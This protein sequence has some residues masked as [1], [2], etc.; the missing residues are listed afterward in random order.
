M[1]I[2]HV[3]RG[4]DHVNNTPRQINILRALGA[5]VPTYA[6]VSMILGDDG[7]K[8]SKR[9]GAVERHGVQKRTATCRRRSSI[10][11][12][13]WAGR[14]ATTRSSRAS[15]WSNG[16]TWTTSPVS[17]PVQHGKTQL[18]ERA[19]HQ[20]GRWRARLTALVQKRLDA[21]AVKVAHS[22]R[23]KRS[24][25]STKERVGNLN[26]ARRRGRRMFYID[27]HPKAEILAQ[28]LTDEA[29]PAL[30]DF[31]EA[32]KTVAWDAPAIGALIKETVGK[33]GRRCQARHAAARAAHRA[34]ADPSVDAVVALFPRET[35]YWHDTRADAK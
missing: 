1:G 34:G 4:D 6:H 18:A 8:L 15:S 35:R 22:R 13:G 14:T 23:W 3:I 7:Q 10:T 33:H 11:W 12:H 5:P 27:L 2:T 31:A 9:H 16:S 24:S 28:H 21:R 20:A 19:L 32:V 17:G 29:K 25:P 26:G 30:A